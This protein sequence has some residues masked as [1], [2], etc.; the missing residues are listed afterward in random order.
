VLRLLNMG[1]YIKEYY[2][3]LSLDIV[4]TESFTLQ[5]LPALLGTPLVDGHMENKLANVQEAMCSLS[6]PDMV[7]REF[8]IRMAL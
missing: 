4:P 3:V 8:F 2:D 5:E 7:R 6:R 1:R